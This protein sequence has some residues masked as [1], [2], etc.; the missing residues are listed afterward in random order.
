LPY[1]KIK[2]LSATKSRAAAPMQQVQFIRFI[3]PALSRLIVAISGD[4]ASG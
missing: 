2:E 1:R 3:R 4:I